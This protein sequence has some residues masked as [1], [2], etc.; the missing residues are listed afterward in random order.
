MTELEQVTQLAD[1]LSPIEQLRLVEHLVERVRT[2][3]LQKK[4][5]QNLY[6]IYKDK[7]PE[8]VDIVPLI[9]EIR[10][11]WKEELHEFEP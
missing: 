5:P 9:R 11:E 10:N 6:G 2:N 7:F 4:K 8:D 1:K 3:A